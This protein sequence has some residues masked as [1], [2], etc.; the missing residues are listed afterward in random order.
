MAESFWQLINRRNSH[1][2]TQKTNAITER[3]G[4]HNVFRQARRKNNCK[5][6]ADWYGDYECGLPSYDGA[7]ARTI[8]KYSILRSFDSRESHTCQ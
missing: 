6:P 1:V 5:L 2:N 3:F 8:F 7:G 4:N